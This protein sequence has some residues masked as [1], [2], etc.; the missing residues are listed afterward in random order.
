MLWALE[1]ALPTRAPPDS[2]FEGVADADAGADEDGIVP[3][4]ANVREHRWQH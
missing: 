4:V 1:Q 3:P 2:F